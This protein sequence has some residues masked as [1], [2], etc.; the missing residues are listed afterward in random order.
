V[1]EPKAAEKAPAAQPA[2]Q[3][4]E[5]GNVAKRLKVLQDSNEALWEQ[6]TR[7]Q[8]KGVKVQAAQ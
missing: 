5:L 8:A 4:P 6:Q 7:T 2:P 1:P 3:E